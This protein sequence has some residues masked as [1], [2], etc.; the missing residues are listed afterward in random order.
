MG[1]TPCISLAGR[2][3]RDFSDLPSRNSPKCP[4]ARGLRAGATDCARSAPA[5][6]RQTG[7]IDGAFAHMALCMA[8][9]TSENSCGGAE[10]GRCGRWKSSSTPFGIPASMHYGAGQARGD[11]IFECAGFAVRWLRQMSW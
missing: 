11:D 1:V 3:W 2:R 6:A 10:V 4:S 5:S 7:S 8:L 9:S